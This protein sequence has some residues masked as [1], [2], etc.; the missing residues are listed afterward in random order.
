[1]AE[2]TPV[3][4]ARADGRRNRELLLAAAHD[5]FVAAPGAAPG[6]ASAVS[7]EKIARAAG[8]GIG[9]LYRH[10][11][12]RE[13]LAEAVYESEL[14]EVMSITDAESLL[15][16]D[17][18]LRAWMNRYATFFAAKRGMLD[19]LRGGWASGAIATPMT[20]QRANAVVGEFLAR[21]VADGS[22][23]DMAAD[24]V[25]A[26]MLGVM[27]STV[28]GASAEPGQTQRLLDLLLVGLR[29]AAPA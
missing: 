17:E 20:R 26:A 16:P 13:A 9:T 6:A 8:V 29:P 12:T 22:L 11:P 3:R 27:L 18:G 5:A 4:K 15:P 28:A 24:D 10:F 19:V 14:D 7:L 2:P 1:M 21:G 25:T 23:R